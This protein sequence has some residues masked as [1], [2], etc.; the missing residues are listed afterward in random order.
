LKQQHC[1]EFI[2][3]TFRKAD[4]ALC[5]RDF[6]NRYKYGTLRNEIKKLVDSGVLLKLPKEC[7]ARFILAEWANRPEYFC[8]RIDDNRGRAAKLD[9]LSCLKSLGW[10]SGLCV[11]NLKLSFQMGNLRWLGKGWKYHSGN[12]SWSRFLELSYPVRVQCFDTHMVLVGI[13]C[14]C[15][16]FP[17]DMKGL[18][19][20]LSLL[21]E[22]KNALHA[23]CVPEP[24]SWIIV[25][26]HLNR[27]TQLGGP[28]FYITFRDFFEQAAQIYYKEEL[29]KVRAEVNQSPKQTIQEILEEILNRDNI[30]KEDA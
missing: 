22:V 24:L 21:G 23:E 5:Y 28:D 20:L 17:L 18:A 29:N 7:P 2:L 30:H 27:D 15:R 12:H 9:L 10:E 13:R 14:S 25:Q 4:R 3:K 6:G 19:S 8:A 26:W 11:H 16:P 1:S